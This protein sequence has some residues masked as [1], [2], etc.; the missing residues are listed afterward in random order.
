MMDI[1][2]KKIETNSKEVTL[3][4]KIPGFCCSVG[5]NLQYS[6]LSHGVGRFATNILGQCI[7]PFVEG[8]KHKKKAFFLN[9]FG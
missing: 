7:G 5:Q 2:K 3:L 9:I 8:Q 1:V 6:G 4:C